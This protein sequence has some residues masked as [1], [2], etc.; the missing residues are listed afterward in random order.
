MW[1]VEDVFEILPTWKE[2]NISALS[3]SNVFDEWKSWC[4]R[5]DHGGLALVAIMKDQVELLNKIRVAATAIGI[6]K[7]AV[8]NQKVGDC[9]WIGFLTSVH[10]PFCF[11]YLDL[12]LHRV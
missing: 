8:K 1:S 3:T 10:L 4:H 9:V 5:H 6:D 11:Q 12:S 2:F 7:G